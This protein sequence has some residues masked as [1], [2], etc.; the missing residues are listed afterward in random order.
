VARGLRREILTTLKAKK[1][2]AEIIDAART[3]FRDRPYEAVSIGDLE[4]AT[5]LTRGPIYY[6]FDGKE[7]IYTTIVVDGLRQIQ[8]DIAAMAAASATPSDFFMA[9][10]REQEGIFRDDKALFDIHFRF[11]F[12]RQNVVRFS[13]ARLS[14]INDIIADAIGTIRLVIEQA[15]ASGRFKCADPHFAALTI[16]GMMVTTLQMDDEAERFRSVGRPREQLLVGLHRQILAML[17]DK[18][19]Q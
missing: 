16:W 13:E 11:F 9:L 18:G 14:E 7:E 1:R 10:I 3:L 8:S 5:G 12:G 2:R 17:G 19:A 4:R 6:Y 15:C